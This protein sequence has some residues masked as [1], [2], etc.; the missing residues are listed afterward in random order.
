ME[1]VENARI[2][3]V[4]ISME[5]HGCL[6]FMI[7]LVGGGWAVNFGG[8]CIGHGYLDADN[9]SAENGAGLVAMMK[10]MDV[11]GVSKWEDLKGKH[12]RIKSENRNSAI[13]VIGNILED[14]WFDVKTFFEEYDKSNI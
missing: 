4:S 9:F 13:H 12:C 7:A 5:D 14:K 8:Y 11:V 3:N 1:F 2:T 6:T 10:I